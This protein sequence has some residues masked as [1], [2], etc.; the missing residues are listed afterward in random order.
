[1]ATEPELKPELL[2]Q[3]DAIIEHG[4]SDGRENP[5]HARAVLKALPALVAAAKERDQLKHYAELE[6]IAGTSMGG[7]RREIVQ[8]RGLLAAAK[9][10]AAE[11]RAELES[12]S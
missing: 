2:A 12:K 1:M 8:L 5:D 4:R 7:M 9:A 3:L 10:D 11:L 6:K